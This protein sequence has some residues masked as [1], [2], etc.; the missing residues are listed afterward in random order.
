MKR[1]ALILALSLLA[2]VAVAAQDKP[3]PEAPKPDAPKADA[4]PAV[5][6]PS[7]DEILDKHVKAIGGKAALEKLNSR[8][9]KGTFEIEAMSIAGPF[10]NYAKA[11]NKVA[12]TFS[13]PGV[14]NGAQVFDGQKA[15]DSNP[16]TGLRELGGEEFAVLK[17]ESDFYRDLNLKKH[18]QKMEVKGKEKVGQ[19]EAYLVEATPTEGGPE[20]L[21]FDANTGLLIRQ[22]AE[23]ETAQGKVAME[24]YMEDYKLVDGVN[25][26]HKVRQITPMFSMTIK[27]AEVKHNV[28]IDDA[29]FAKPAGN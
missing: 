21:Y 4:K 27:F 1:I 17:R 22:D 10:E 26:P 6:L 7:V 29:K 24:V 14:G 25:I 19:S 28:E 13:I 3:K 11:P 8:A 9:A 2:A 12:V 20:K 23:R 18:Y 15:W 16:M 5:A